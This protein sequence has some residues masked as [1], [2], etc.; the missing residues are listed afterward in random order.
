VIDPGQSCPTCERRV[1]YPKTEKSPQTK[2]IA[3]RVPLDEIESH[4]DVAVTAARFIGV[5]E[6]PHWRY[7]LN[8]YAYTHVLQDESMKGIASKGM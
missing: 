8:T 3:Y 6:R 1:P 7:L 4:E 2:S 5:H